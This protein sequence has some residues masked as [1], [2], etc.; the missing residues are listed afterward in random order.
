MTSDSRPSRPLLF[1]PDQHADAHE[2]VGEF[3]RQYLA[4]VAERPV[5]PPVDRAALHKIRD[6]SLPRHGQA[7]EALFA[8]LET[9]IVPNST[10]TAHPRF[11]PYVQPS[12]NAL[13]PYADH[14]AAVLNQNCN[15]WHLS[16]A[17]NIVEQTLLRWFADLFGLPAS[18]GGIMTSGGSMA[19]L[20]ALTAARDHALGKSARTQ[21]LQSGGTPLVLYTSEQVH[22][23]IDKAVSILG[24]GTDNLRRIPTDDHFRMRLD[25]LHVAVAADRAAGCRPFCVVASAGT[26]TTGA[27]DPIA[28]LALFCREQGLWLHVDGAYGALAALSDRFREPMRV[29]GLADSVS[30]D[31]HKFLFCA[32]EAGC[33]LVRDRQHLVNAF[34]VQPSYLTMSEDP[35]FIDFANQGPQLSRAFKA[36]KVWWSLKHFGADAFASTIERMHDLALH[37]GREIERRAAFELLAPVVFNCVCFRLRALDDAGNRRVLKSLVDGGDAFLGPASVKGRNGLRACFMNLRTEHSDVDFIL[38]R[39]QTLAED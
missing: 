28:E 29:I 35:D 13:S 1:T 12:P 21:G 36:L 2:R 3:S 33:V 17:A 20:V 16:P 18:T 10:H 8:E 7:L 23:S 15:L 6:E 14:V 39:I 37:M 31:P 9:L 30:L 22:S 38:D 11:L 4:T 34:S 5:Y 26:V 27:I 32:F 25:A 19:N 24:L